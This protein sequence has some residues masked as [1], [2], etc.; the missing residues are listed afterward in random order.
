M[1]SRNG[2]DGPQA[3]GRLLFSDLHGKEE[4]SVS[5]EGSPE[6][7]QSDVEDEGA[8]ERTG[9]GGV[10][11]MGDMEDMYTDGDEPTQPLEEEDGA[12]DGV[13]GAPPGPFDTAN[14][15]ALRN[16]VVSKTAPVKK[17]RSRPT[18]P[19]P[20]S[21]A[22]ERRIDSLDNTVTTLQA[23][24]K[25]LG[26]RVRALQISGDADGV[27]GA[28]PAALGELRSGVE[29]LEKEC[30]IIMVT[31]KEQVHPAL[32]SRIAFEAE[33]RA[34]LNGLKS[35]VG[36]LLP[37]KSTASAYGERLLK[38]ELAGRNA[39]APVVPSKRA[40]DEDRPLFAFPG[41]HVQPSDDSTMRMAPM[42]THRPSVSPS[43][44]PG[45]PPPGGP[46]PPVS[47]PNS[48]PNLRRPPV[49]VVLVKIEPVDTKG[50]GERPAL[51]GWLN[52]AK[53]SPLPGSPSKKQLVDSVEGV[54]F[55]GELT[56]LIVKTWTRPAA[57]EFADAWN[58][59]VKRTV[60]LCAGS[61]AETM[62]Q[63]N[64][65]D[66]TASHRVSIRS[67]NIHGNFALRMACSDFFEEIS[68]YDIH[69][70]QETHMHSDWFGTVK[71]VEGQ[72]G[73][74]V[75]LV[76]DGLGFVKSDE[77][78][79]V[80]V[81]VLESPELVLVGVYILPEGSRWGTFTDISPFV[82]LEELM[83]SLRMLE[84]PVM[85][86][87][88]FNARIGSSGERVLDDR[89][90]RPSARGKVL[91][92]ICDDNGFVICNGLPRFGDY[93]QRITSHHRG[94]GTAVVDYVIG[95]DRAMAKVISMGVGAE[96]AGFSDHAELFVE[97]ECGG[98]RGDAPSARLPTKN[99]DLP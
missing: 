52:A 47:A 83:V 50:V 48:L 35:D 84:K 25:E 60:A 54:W 23:T 77:L 10:D 75:A 22:L 87:G 42:P 11:D 13:P 38:L 93:G 19:S 1:T 5:I 31:L 90:T 12:R 62:V 37:L 15:R 91:L 57:Y 63:E 20:A 82:E 27:G 17:S 26:E 14:A 44:G 68:Q 92:E 61:V 53:W 95:N 97:V 85:L 3:G 39:P 9:M 98:Q 70:F 40:R 4:D 94:V 2:D 46:P 8:E 36:S 66:N 86:M 21:F 41:S 65:L 59:H 78:S 80:D 45:G 16:R 89:I 30:R 96:R 56:H 99:R 71:E 67:W 69:F 34:T 81:L 72:D 24:V 76:R 51:V 49:K 64:W 32:K 58:T 6:L 28:P 73:G 79:S 43:R 29:G 74:V 7:A 18:L 55:S 33:A 88:D